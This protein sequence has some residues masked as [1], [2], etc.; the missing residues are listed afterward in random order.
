MTTKSHVQEF[1]LPFNSSSEFDNLAKSLIT[2]A[3]TDTELAKLFVQVQIA[4]GNGRDLLDKKQSQRYEKIKPL[5]GFDIPTAPSW[6]HEV[7]VASYIRAKTNL[8]PAIS[9]TILSDPKQALRRTLAIAQKIEPD[10][11]GELIIETAR[12]AK[13]S[14]GFANTLKNTAGEYRSMVGIAIVLST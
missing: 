6:L 2:A 14:N 7:L 10:F 1:L 4:L 3:K 8:T 5:G 9:S 12:L 13:K 11:I